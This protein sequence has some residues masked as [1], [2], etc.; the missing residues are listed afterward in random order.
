[1]P[2]ALKRQVLL[3]STHRYNTNLKARKSNGSSLINDM[4]GEQKK[5][6]KCI[7]ICISSSA[8]ISIRITGLAELRP[9]LPS[10]KFAFNFKVAFA[11]VKE[12]K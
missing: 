11:N 9:Y 2:I 4:S 1:L 8:Y 10:K 5:V 7:R 3:S 6:C 12:K